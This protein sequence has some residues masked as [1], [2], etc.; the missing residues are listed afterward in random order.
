M[1]IADQ[2]IELRPQ[3]RIAQHFE[4]SREDRSVLLTE[5]S[6]D[7]VAIG[8]NFAC[9]GFNGGRK[10]LQLRFDRIARDEPVRNPKPL[11][12]HHHRFANG[13]AR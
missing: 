13:D 4:M 6:V 8:G 11:G 2:R 3:G 1:P 10:T 5:F 7:G 12:V 9:R